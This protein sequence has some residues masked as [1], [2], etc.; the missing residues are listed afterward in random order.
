VLF[1]MLR[2]TLTEA[3]RRTSYAMS[4]DT[5]RPQLPALL[6]ERRGGELRF[7]ATDGHRLALT[8]TADAGPDF[9][10]LVGRQTVEEVERMV[11]AFGGLVRLQRERDRVWFVAGDEFVSGPVVDA[12][13]PAYEHVIPATPEGRVILATAELAAA[14]AAL[15][16]RRDVGINFQFERLLDRA[17]LSVDDGDGGLAQ[18]ALAASY[19]GTLPDRLGL[20]ARYLR[21]LL[22]ALGDERT[23]TLQVNGELDPVQ[24]D[25]A[26]MTAV[27]M[28]MRV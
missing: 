18:T 10:V 11:G 8:R 24:E 12:V 20:N 6:I 2:P 1:A 17:A 21:D 25:A 13:F 16:P 3:L 26:G 7:V 4:C 14:V 5:T 15:V 27:V 19:E 9:S 28:P 22:G 23:F